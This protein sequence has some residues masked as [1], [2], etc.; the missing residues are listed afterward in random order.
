MFSSI[1]TLIFLVPVFLI[2][3]KIDVNVYRDALIFYGK[4]DEKQGEMYFQ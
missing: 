3:H 2:L 4:H 1:V